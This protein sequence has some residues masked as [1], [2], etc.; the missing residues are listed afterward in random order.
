MSGNRPADADLSPLPVRRE[1]SRGQAKEEGKRRE[2]EEKN[3]IGESLESCGP[4]ENESCVTATEAEAWALVT[5][6][7]KLRWNISLSM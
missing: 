7:K 1:S 4:Q 6:K 2:S 5:G 3:N